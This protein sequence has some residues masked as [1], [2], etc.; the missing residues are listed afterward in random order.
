MIDDFAAWVRQLPPTDGRVYLEKIPGAHRLWV[1]HP[2][3]RNA[4][5]PQMMVQLGE[6]VAALPPG[7]VL[8][9]G[10]GGTFC[11]GGNLDALR[12]HLGEP[13]A[14]RVFG[15][16]MHQVALALRARRDPVVAVVEG[17]A[18]GGGAELAMAAHAVVAHPSA[19]IG[20][21][22]ARLGVSPGFGGGR[23]LCER[24]GPVAT[25]RLL[26]EAALGPVVEG[27]LVQR[28]AESPVEAALEVA[29][30]LSRHPDREAPKQWENPTDGELEE[31][32]DVQGLDATVRAGILR[33]VRAAGRPREVA[34]QV[35]LEVF[36]S[37]WGGPVHRAA[38]E[39]VRR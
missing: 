24:I 2:R 35:E 16:Y 18:L 31:A 3:S 1:D 20:F 15:G 36:D 7:P 4:L 38:L 10:A 8:V 5:G 30:E 11:S 6:L 23:W 14:G 27:P 29:E 33:I 28:V 39:R 34:L 19:R 17:V 32:T 22:Q 26:A 12:E 9:Q 21:V 37:L 25:A 13:R